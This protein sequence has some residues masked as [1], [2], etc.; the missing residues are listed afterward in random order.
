MGKALWEA[1]AWLLWVQGIWDRVQG[2]LEAAVTVDTA[3]LVEGQLTLVFGVCRGDI[4]SFHRCLSCM[5]MVEAKQLQVE[6][7]AEGKAG[8]R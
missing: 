6:T 8:R 2:V 7:F 3:Y 4:H 5:G 1:G